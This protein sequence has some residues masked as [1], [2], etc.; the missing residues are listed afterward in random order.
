MRKKLHIILFAV[1]VMLF[2]SVLTVYADDFSISQTK[3]TVNIGDTIDLDITGTEKSPRWTSWN[4]NTVKVN[5]DGEITAVRKG[6]TTVSARIGLSFKKCTVTVVDPT[7]K[8]N[9]K[10]ATIYTGGSSAKTVQLKAT[11]KGASKTVTWE[12]SAPEIAVVDEKGKVTSVSAG[13][14][15][16][17]AKANGESA[18][19][20]VTVKESSISLNM[21][22][23]Q[24]G[25]KGNG[26][27]IKLTPTVVG[28]SK[29]VKWTTSDKKIATVSGGKVTG[30]GSGTVT[31]TATANGVS[32]TCNVTVIKDSVSLSSEKELL[33][34]GETKQLKSN[35]GKKDVV[36]WSSSNEA[37]ATVADGKV[38]AVGAGNAV[39]SI[40]RNGTT[41]VCEIT[42]KDTSTSIGEDAVELKTKGTHKTYTLGFEVVGRNSAVK[43][44]TSDK[45]VATVSKGKITAKKAGSVTITATANGVSDTV[46]V[47]VKDYDPTIKLSQNEY[48]LYTKKGNTLTLKA[49]VDGASKK[50]TWNSSD[51]SV[52]TVTAKGKVTA[53]KEGTALITATANDVTTECLITVMESKVIL[54]TENI[55]LEKGGTAK[56]PVDVVGSSQTVSY[57]TT[58]GK[59]AAVKKGVITAKNYGEADIKITANGV[60]SVCHVYVDECVHMF[61]EGAVTTEPTCLEEGIVTYTC[62]KCGDVYT[63]KADKSEHSWKES[64]KSESTCVSSGMITFTCSVCGETKQEIT[65]TTDHSYGKWIVITEATEI[66]EGLEKQ[67][68]EFCKA[69]NERTIPKKGHEHVYVSSVTEP[70]C[71][72]KGYTTYTCACGDTYTD[73]YMDALDH[74]WGEWATTKEPTETEAGEKKRVCNR[75]S[76]EETAEIPVTTHEHKYTS[77]VIEPTCTEQGY[78]TYTCDCNDS[79][80]DDYTDALGH[81]YKLVET[82]EPTC[83]EEGKTVESCDICG[84]TKTEILKATG[85]KESEL[86]T[87][88]EAT[89]LGEGEQHTECSV[90]H[91]T[92]KTETIPATGHSE[93][94]WIVDK[95]ASCTEDGFKH[96]ECGNCG[97]TISTETITSSGHSMDGWNTISEA[98]CETD[99]T[100]ERNCSKCSYSENRSIPA[101]GHD[102]G[103]WIVDEEPTEE[104]EGSKHKEC[105]NC[106]DTITEDIEQLPPHVHSYDETSRTDSTCTNVGSVTYSC[107]CGD[108]YSEEIA[109]KSHVSGDWIVETAPTEETTGLEVKKCTECG[110]QTDSRIIEKLEHVHNYTTE[111]KDATCTTDG[112]EKKTC[113][114]GSIINTVI[115]ATGHNYVES[116]KE[117]AVCGKD[118]SVTYKCTNCQDSYSEKI[119]QLVHEYSVTSTVNATCTEDGYVI[120]TC[121]NCKDTITTSAGEATGHDDGEWIVTQEA[122]VGVAGLKELQCTKC[123]YALESEEIEMLLTDGTDSVYY[124]TVKNDDGTKTEEIVVGHYNEE[125]ADEMLELVNNYRVENGLTA[126]ELKTGYMEEYTDL[127]AAETSYL[128]DHARPAGWGTECSENIA[129]GMPDMKGN[130][131]SVEEIFNAWVAS[132]GHRTNILTPFTKNW[133]GISVFYKRCP[134]AGT[135][136][137]VYEA[138]WVQTFK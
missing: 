61:D 97:T 15:T 23:L 9:K 49:T 55:H 39:V 35:A 3:V 5:Q 71:T 8:V 95:D 28:S 78:I 82:K 132:E 77:V 84:N 118:G 54:E 104:S 90:C 64:A 114:C 75:C 37:V 22:S 116:E 4:V 79:Y 103:D 113:G 7:I 26:S 76:T 52:A 36:T 96:T 94:D 32:A 59:V 112:Y 13:T 89:C 63:E 107:D 85:H 138:Y 129:M 14:A 92:L 68:C 65:E 45:T 70:T 117:D 136:R 127:R 91:I 41:D 106:G 51:T 135:D 123:E 109:K 25:T 57:K 88:K 93:G 99:G 131:V 72:E 121:K 67:Y 48:T 46:K 53:L 38:T 105:A 137:Y 56:L 17:T 81:S 24:L 20:A 122:D 101:T 33:Y 108:S 30:K 120:E 130:T 86:I 47:T 134:I 43:W 74:N 102:Y 42:V 125:E 40:E 100:E 133:T 16:I 110:T 12:S 115:P 34:T 98:G 11:A 69:E 124:I 21:D 29:S 128:W 80:V 66:T 19:C 10:V 2:A 58:N 6:K 27:S 87:D 119:E 31:I 126:L 1:L 62:T 111:S 83:T 50:V 18:S 60:T 73:A 44:T